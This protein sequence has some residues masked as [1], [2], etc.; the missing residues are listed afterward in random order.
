M[1]FSE[2]SQINFNGNGN[3]AALPTCGSQAQQQPRVS[4]HSW[5]YNPNSQYT[6]YAGY[7]PQFAAAVYQGYAPRFQMPANVS[8]IHYHK[9]VTPYSR[10]IQ[11][12]VP[13]GYGYPQMPPTQVVAFPGLQAPA[14]SQGLRPA[15]PA[16]LTPFGAQLWQRQRQQQLQA[17]LVRRR[18]LQLQQQSLAAARSVAGPPRAAAVAAAP[19]AQAQRPQAQDVV[20][21]DI[22][23]GSML[24]P[25]QPQQ[26][27]QQ[28]QAQ[29]EAIDLTADDDEDEVQIV[30]TVERQDQEEVVA[31]PSPPRAPLPESTKEFL[32]KLR[33]FYKGKGIDAVARGACLF[34]PGEPQQAAKSDKKRK[35]ADKDS[36]DS[37]SS[38]PKAKKVRTQKNAPET[39]EKTVA[40]VSVSESTTSRA[41]QE[42]V[43]PEAPVPAPAPAPAAVEGSSTPA[44][45]SSAPVEGSSASAAATAA[46]TT[47]AVKKK[48]LFDE[49]EFMRCLISDDEDETS[50]DLELDMDPEPNQDRPA[51]P[52]HVSELEL[53]WQAVADRHAL[54]VGSV[55]EPRSMPAEPKKRGRPK[56]VKNKSPE[57]KAAIQAEKEKKQG[58]TTASKSAPKK[59]KS[60]EADSMT[61]GKDDAPQPKK[62]RVLKEAQE[63]PAPVYKNERER[64]RAEGRANNKAA[65][66]A[67]LTALHGDSTASATPESSPDAVWSPELE[68][69]H[70]SEWSP[71]PEPSREH[72]QRATTVELLEAEFEAEFE[73]LFEAAEKAQSAAILESQSTAESD[74][75]PRPTQKAGEEGDESHEEYSRRLVEKEAAKKADPER[76]ARELA[77]KEA[78]EKEEAEK[79]AAEE[80]S[81][82]QARAAAEAKRAA[83]EE[84][85]RQTQ[86]ELDNDLFGDNDDNDDLFGDNEK[87]EDVEPEPTEEQKQEAAAAAAA[88]ER[89]RLIDGDSVVMELRGKIARRE[90]DMASHGSELLKRKLAKAIAETQAK[91]DERIEELQASV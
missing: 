55:P 27:Q 42:A 73:A 62:A 48:P 22:S 14:G 76:F 63:K 12:A 51:I 77:E 46:P 10:Q 34:A 56:G 65:K 1:D 49:E 82:K 31:A 23:V 83:E 81:R 88:A 5:L 86:E 70:E 39:A 18:Q 87:E 50:G 32:Q 57:Q 28:Q 40:D 43:Q 59:R 25:A 20:A 35:S 58:K 19:A 2:R 29:Q 69:S 85:A 24:P 53:I 9:C 66:E 3:M 11:T 47:P 37:G 91:L 33:G 80:Q 89:Q 21:S 13:R 84:A 45:N 26:E 90:Q 68:P 15:F 54:P 60:C 64:K 74:A 6:Q 72:F 30:K 71:E 38:E 44:E 67:F 75:Q 41:A 79:R 78:K 8:S 36:A 4:Q 7:Q 17:Q 16:G 61:V 52:A